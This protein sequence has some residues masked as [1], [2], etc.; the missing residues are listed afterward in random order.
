MARIVPRALA[1]AKDY[2]GASILISSL[3]KWE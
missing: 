2:F 1:E 3:S